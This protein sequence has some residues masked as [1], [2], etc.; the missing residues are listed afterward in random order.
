MVDWSKQRYWEDVKEGE[1][2]PGVLINI[3]E[4][5]MV[6]AAAGNRDFN[7]H[8]FVEAIAHQHGAP[9]IFANNVFIQ[10][11]WERC[12]REYIGMGG[13]VKKVGP[14][15]IRTFNMAGDAV[16][17]KGTVKRKWQENGQNLVEL[18]VW[19]EKQNGTVCVGPGPVLVTLPTRAQAPR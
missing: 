11:M 1:Q 19:S 17:T 6:I 14:F 9:H 18:E 2:V 7:P 15:R 12:I 3:T 5:R 4:E 16:T 13:W 10:S 8:Q